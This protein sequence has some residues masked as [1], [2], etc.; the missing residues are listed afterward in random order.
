MN[1]KDELLKFKTKIIGSAEENTTINVN[2]TNTPINL[3]DKVDEFINWYYKNMVKG[4]YTDI[5]EYHFPRQM[6]DLIEK[7]EYGMN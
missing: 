6:R 3:D 4:K 1:V 2:S 7:I 5:G